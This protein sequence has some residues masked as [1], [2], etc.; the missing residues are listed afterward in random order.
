MSHPNPPPTEHCQP[1]PASPLP[2]PTFN[3]GL[4]TGHKLVDRAQGGRLLVEVVHQGGVPSLKKEDL[5]YLKKGDDEYWERMHA[6]KPPALERFSASDVAIA[7]L[8]IDRE[9]AMRMRPQAF[10]R[11]FKYLSDAQQLVEG[12]F[13]EMGE[14][15]WAAEL[16]K[17]IEQALTDEEKVRRGESEGFVELSEPV[18]ESPFFS[19]LKKQQPP[20]KMLEWK[21]ARALVKAM[22][23]HGIAAYK[24]AKVWYVRAEE[25]ARFTKLESERLREADKK[26]Q[27]KSRSRKKRLGK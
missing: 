18:E 25:V 14:S 11:A 4:L 10:R 1:K 23:A 17:A 3:D 2:H 7:A 22:A 9:N 19:L 13:V 6:Q 24:Y 16:D 8:L 21:T 20:K 15:E 26:R 27:S 5:N 12:L